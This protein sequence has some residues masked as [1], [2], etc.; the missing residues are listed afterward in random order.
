MSNKNVEAL[1]EEEGI[2]VGINQ[3][4]IVEWDLP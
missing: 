1:R 3:I 2:K 4:K